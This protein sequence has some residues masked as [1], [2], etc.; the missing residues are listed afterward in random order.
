MNL[1]NNIAVTRTTFAQNL[2]GV[3]VVVL[4][5]PSGQCG[6]DGIGHPNISRSLGLPLPRMML[7]C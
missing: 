4:N 2:A 7:L 5:T 6:L 1:R 3:N